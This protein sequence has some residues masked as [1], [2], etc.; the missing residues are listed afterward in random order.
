MA[1]NIQKLVIKP[2]IDTDTPSFLTR[3]SARDLINWESLESGNYG[4]R[5]VKGYQRYA[6]G[7]L[8]QS[9]SFQTIY[10][11]SGATDVAENDVVYTVSGAM[12]YVLDAPVVTS[13]SYSGGDAVGYYPVVTVSGVF[14]VGDSVLTG[15]PGADVGYI[16][17]ITVDLY[18]GNGASDTVSYKR[19]AWTKM[20]EFI[21][22]VSGSGPVKG[23][24]QVNNKV[25]AF[26]DNTE[27]TLLN[28]YEAQPDNSWKLNPSYFQ[29]TNTNSRVKTVIGSFGGKT[30]AYCV[31]G[32]DK[33]FMYDGYAFEQIETGMPEGMYPTLVEIF[34]NQLFLFYPHTNDSGGSLIFS[35]IDDPTD[36]TTTSR[37]AGEIAFNYTAT[38]IINLVGHNLAIMG[39]VIDVLSVNS[40]GSMSVQRFAEN[41]NCEP[42]SAQRLSDVL[43]LSNK[44]VY[45]LN[46]TNKYGD[47]GINSLNEEANALMSYVADDPPLF[48]MIVL[49]KAQY[50]L[51]FNNKIVI[52][53][54][55]I[56]KENYWIITRQYVNDNFTT[57]SNPNITNGVTTFYYG[58]EKG[59]VY[60]ADSG[61][62][63]DDNDIV[64]SMKTCILDFGNPEVKKRWRKL[65]IPLSIG[66]AELMLGVKY[67]DVDDFRYPE[68]HYY[69]TADEAAA[70]GYW[71]IDYWNDFDWAI[72][73]SNTKEKM[74]TLH[75]TG[76]SPTLTF[77][78]TV[79]N[80]GIETSEFSTAYLHYTPRNRL[81]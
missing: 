29:Q 60:L 10:F 64:A 44:R 38:G 32:Y 46:A 30:K 2:T 3:N 77:Y 18:Y 1:V 52:V 49:E 51:Y 56:G 26:R 39:N 57:V 24:I 55:N 33:P 72:S 31:T 58:D 63:F 16:T 25:V 40:D 34:N 69:Y 20:R 6:G 61:Y 19:K 41:L 27:G 42:S 22:T 68:S 5:L 53:L 74:Y 73:E 79:F 65:M 76:T 8:A 4:I 75:L 37:G 7:K 11:A 62:L 23:I 15:H 66:S 36:Y 45:A 21:P 13:G 67:N 59:Y 70:A 14:N 48:S 28:A 12:A 78:V 47:F 54:T 50:R 80:K 43:Y 71:N 81:R 9:Y 17:D 35:A